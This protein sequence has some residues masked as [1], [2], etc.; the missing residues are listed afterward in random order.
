M[1]TKQG[2]KWWRKG[3]NTQQKKIKQQKKRWKS[4]SKLPALQCLFTSGWTKFTDFLH[5]KNQEYTHTRTRTHTHTHTHNTCC[6]HHIPIHK[7]T[8]I[9]LKTKNKTA[10]ETYVC[11]AHHQSEPHQETKA[12]FSRTS[13]R[14]QKRS[15]SRPCPRVGM[16]GRALLRSRKMSRTETR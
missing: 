2:R 1:S 4:F 15:S 7:H 5:F 3:I 10:T 8:H 16:E 14:A 13:A 6:I 11:R 9:L 12:M